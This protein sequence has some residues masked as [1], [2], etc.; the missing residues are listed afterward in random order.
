MPSRQPTIPHAPNRLLTAFGAKAQLHVVKLMHTLPPDISSPLRHSSAL[1]RYLYL[2]CFRS[3]LSKNS[4]PRLASYVSACIVDSCR[5]VAIT[6]VMLGDANLAKCVDWSLSIQ[7]A[8]VTA[9]PSRTSPH[10]AAHKFSM[11]AGSR[12]QDQFR[13]CFVARLRL[14]R[15]PCLVKTSLQSKIG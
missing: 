9:P 15:S 6:G 8:R 13:A 11:F 5:F 2:S 12:L 7:V 10:T 1:F 4:L 3:L 14:A